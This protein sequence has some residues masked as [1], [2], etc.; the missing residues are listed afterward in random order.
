[1][2]NRRQDLASYR[3]NIATEKFPKELGRRTARLQQMREKSDYDD[4]SLS[5]EMMHNYKLNLPN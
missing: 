1:M 4:F 5:P 2:D 3:M